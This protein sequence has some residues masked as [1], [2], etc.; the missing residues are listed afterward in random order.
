MLSCLGSLIIRRI[1]KNVYFNVAH[2]LNKRIPIS[3][4]YD[5]FYWI[6]TQTYLN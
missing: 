5:L 2:F 6:N 4:E 1:P 3:K